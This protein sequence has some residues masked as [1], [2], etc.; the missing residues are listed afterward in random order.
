M[1][2][3][4]ELKQR[5]CTAEDFDTETRGDRRS[6][7]GFFPM[8]EDT[9]GNIESVKGSIKCIDEQYMIE[10]HFDS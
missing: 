2:E 10:G 5:A 7:Y 1:P 4:I 9:K 6:R 3:F 8:G